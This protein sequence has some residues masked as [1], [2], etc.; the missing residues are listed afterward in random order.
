MRALFFTDKLSESATLPGK[1]ALV[2]NLFALLECY[3]AS[4][5]GKTVLVIFAEPGAHARHPRAI[6]SQGRGDRGSLG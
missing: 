6:R 4:P 5:T 3:P 1:E 2:R